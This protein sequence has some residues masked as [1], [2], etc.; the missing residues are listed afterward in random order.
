M[1][2]ECIN[3]IRLIDAKKNNKHLLFEPFENTLMFKDMKVIQELK[4]KI[5]NNFEFKEKSAS[6]PIDE[7]QI[8]Y[9]G[10]SYPFTI[11]FLDS[12]NKRNIVVLLDFLFQHFVRR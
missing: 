12:S 1:C 5:E 6:Y 4:S 11:N 2:I 3:E 8:R 7:L 10:I 9:G